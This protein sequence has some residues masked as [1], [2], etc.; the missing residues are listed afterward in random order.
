[1]WNLHGIGE[2]SLLKWSSHLL[3][4]IIVNLREGRGLLAG[5]LP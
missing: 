1:M 4:F 3:F 2:E 5:I